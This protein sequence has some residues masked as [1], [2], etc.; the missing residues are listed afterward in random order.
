MSVW[1]LW[2]ALVWADN[3]QDALPLPMEP[4][5]AHIWERGQR[6]ER[7]GDPQ[8]AMIAY[9][10]VV[11]ENPGWVSGILA[12]G[13]TTEAAG[14]PEDALLV[15]RRSSVPEVLVERARVQ[16]SLGRSE[17]ALATYERLRRSAPSAEVVRL[18]SLAMAPVDAT[19]AADRVR[20]WLVWLDQT[21]G[22]S[23]LPNAELQ[24][25]ADGVLFVVEA[26]VRAEMDEDA[27][28]LLA[29]VVDAHPALLAVE[30]MSERLDSMLLDGEARR[31]MRSG[32]TDLDIEQSRRLAEAEEALRNGDAD[33]ARLVID[34]LL[35]DAPR[36]PDAWATRARIALATG[37]IA[38][39]DAALQRAEFLAPTDPNYAAALGDLLATSYAGREDAAAVE[40]Y[41]RALRRDPLWAEVWWRRAR[42]EQRSGLADRGYAALE[43]YLA[44]EP[45]GEHATDAGRLLQDLRRARPDSPPLPEQLDL[46]NGVSYGALLAYHR[47]GV[48]RAR[49]DND[50]ARDEVRRVRALAP[51]FA[52]AVNL[53][54]SLFLDVGDREHAIGAYQQSL[55]LDPAQPGVVLTLWDLLKRE[56]READAEA[57]VRAAEVHGIGDVHYLLA[58]AAWEVNEPSDASAQLDAFFATAHTARFEVP[59]RDLRREID[60]RSQ[61]IRTG[62][63]GG[64]SLLLGLL[65]AWPL[66]RWFRGPGVSLEAFVLQRPSV[67]REVVHSAAAI[68]HEVLKHDTTVLFQVADAL[69][70]GD[71]ET[72]RWAAERLF[73]PRGTVARFREH[74][75]ALNDAARGQGVRLDLRRRD[76][77]FSPLIG[78]VDRL[79]GLQTDLLRGRSRAVPELRQVAFALNEVGFAELGTLLHSLSLVRVDGALIGEVV[80]RVRREPALAGAPDVDLIVGAEP[81][82]VRMFRGELEDLVANLVRNALGV[83]RDTQ[84]GDVA[85]R[86]TLDVDELTYREQVRIAVCDNIPTSLSTADIHERPMERGLGIARELVVKNDGTIGVG[87][88]A[89]WAKAVEV[90]LPAVEVV[91]T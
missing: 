34:S 84:S 56:G 49:G 7:D 89:G 72:A 37:E 74:I 87:V 3:P 86:V 33:T 91:P 83:S 12:L 62:I 26:L 53:E 35:Q 11:R 58:R 8:S 20:E 14:R 57:V 5:I 1:L 77:V 27:T 46:P 44:L 21:A 47:V 32:A 76:P 50:A 82:W 88:E 19:A 36:A 63:V 24:V 70:Q 42:V 81:M 31:W 43:R 13:R 38:E 48:L 28:S 41:R 45:G 54:A 61:R 25:Q 10:I 22:G 9:S 65:L 17:E 67:A 15:Y 16:L 23:A 4:A 79:V 71:G 30:G 78:A 90:F 51:D 18:Q 75:D 55:I 85:V 2:V 69:E 39:A 6:S 40:A 68:R 29:H 73:A 64:V 66:Y 59:A 52:D 80:E 60:D